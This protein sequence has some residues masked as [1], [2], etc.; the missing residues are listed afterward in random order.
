MEEVEVVVVVV[1]EEDEEEEVQGDPC[2]K[3][4]VHPRARKPAA[5]HA[6]IETTPPWQQPPLPTL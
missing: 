5:C 3:S 1:E 2:P 6:D 4:T